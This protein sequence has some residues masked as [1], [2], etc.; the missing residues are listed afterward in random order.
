[1]D[2]VTFCFHFFLYCLHSCL[3]SA[4]YITCQHTHTHTIINFPQLMESKFRKS[5]ERVEDLNSRCETQKRENSELSARYN[6]LKVLTYYTVGG[7]GLEGCVN[8]CIS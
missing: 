6:A 8:I 7:R 3:P 4:V 5:Q 2:F 1:M